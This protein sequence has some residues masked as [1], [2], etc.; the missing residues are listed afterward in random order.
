MPDR[1][2]LH[3][4]MHKTGTTAVQE[5]LAGYDD[6]DTRV[7]RLRHPNHSIQMLT[8]F[9]Q[10][11]TKY[12]V[13]VRQGIEPE[14]VLRI[15]AAMRR[16]LLDELALPRRQLVISGEEMSLMH[17]PSVLEMADFLAPH[18][19]DVSV[20]AWLRPAVGY[21][22][23]ALQQMIRAGQA[24][25]LLPRPCYRARFAMF[26]QRYGV[27]A[28]TYRLYQEGSSTVTDFCDLLGIPP[29]SVQDRRDNVSLSD[30]ALRLIW[31]LN[32]TGPVTTGSA[33]RLAAR[34]ATIR[35]LARRFPG[36]FALP[37]DLAAAGVDRDDIAWAE[38]A[39]GLALSNDILDIDPATAQ[40]RLE[41]W[42]GSVAEDTEEALDADLE[43]LG[44][45]TTR[46]ADLAE[47]VASLYRHYLD[48]SEGEAAVKSATVSIFRAGAR[49][50]GAAI[51]SRLGTSTP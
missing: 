16:E 20:L 14:R 7:A 36:R 25:A 31:L 30:T 48:Q 9:A 6:G 26:A 12:H 43:Q 38:A 24:T 29:Q 51:K 45:R 11:P 37:P 46:L 8:C 27:G 50:S 15:R 33:A 44:L 35:H 5:A 41:A 39:T 22:G 34:S 1:L 10:D 49:D 18:A 13:W 42:L 17:P 21:I 28:M 3:V 32:R 47:R 19:R 2:I 23:S 40:R 4:G